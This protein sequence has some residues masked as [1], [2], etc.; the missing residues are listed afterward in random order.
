METPVAIPFNLYSIDA[1]AKD[2]KDTLFRLALHWLEK[3][4]RIELGYFAIAQLDFYEK[5]T[6]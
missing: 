6:G 1:D 4:G 3:L 2:D 5:F